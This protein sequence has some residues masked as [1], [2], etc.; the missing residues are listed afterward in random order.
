MMGVQI[1]KEQRRTWMTFRGTAHGIEVVEVLSKV[2]FFNTNPISRKNHS[3]SIWQLQQC[4]FFFPSCVIAVSHDH[5]LCF[6]F[7]IADFRPNQA[8][9]NRQSH[10]AQESQQG[11]QDPY[12]GGVWGGGTGQ[13]HG[14]RAHIK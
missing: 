11:H 8:K 9:E 2:M 14:E 13:E 12:G 7:I 3:S 4:F 1:I 10:T 6:L 5:N